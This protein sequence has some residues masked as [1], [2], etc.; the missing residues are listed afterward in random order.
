MN[1]IVNHTIGQKHPPGTMVRYKNGAIAEVQANGQFKIRRGATDLSG[2][3]GGPRKEITRKKAL[4][5]FNNYYNNKVYKTNASRKSAKTR[6]MCSDNHPLRTTTTFSKSP[7][8]YDY[9]GLDDGTDP[10]CKR[11]IHKR[12]ATRQQ[13][14]ILARGRDKR[15]KNKYQLRENRLTNKKKLNT[16]YDSD[17]YLDKLYDYDFYAFHTLRNLNTKPDFLKTLE[18]FVTYGIKTNKVKQT[19]KSV[20]E[21]AFHSIDDEDEPR[22]SFILK[23]PVFGILEPLFIKHGPVKLEIVLE[24]CGRYKYI[25]DNNGL[26]IEEIVLADSEFFKTFNLIILLSK[27]Y[28]RPIISFGNSIRD[29][30]IKKVVESGILSRINSYNYNTKLDGRYKNKIDL[31]KMKYGQT[32]YQCRQH[33]PNSISI[34]KNKKKRKQANQKRKKLDREAELK[35]KTQSQCEWVPRNKKNKPRCENKV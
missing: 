2:L 19:L 24:A 18:E 17:F 25:A 4:K 21:L 31:N 32:Q 6:D 28:G 13:R 9:P 14:E 5:A 7:Y 16:L 23:E 15:N 34:P 8:R 27:I 29:K 11:V 22:S 10:N 1:N 20:L 30:Q 3:N 12:I 33:T 26:S 35:C